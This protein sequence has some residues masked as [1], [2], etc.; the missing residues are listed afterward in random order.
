MARPAAE[1]AAPV[2]PAGPAGPGAAGILRLLAPLPGRLEL[3]TRVAAA[4]AL[5]VLVTSLYGT[6][7]AAIS[8]YLVFFLNRADRTSSVVMSIGALVLISLVI[9]LVLL[10]AMASIDWPLW[11]VMWMTVLSAGLLFLTSASKLRP[12]G[13][14]LAMIVGFGLDQLGLAPVG[15]AATRALLYAWLMVAIPIGANVAINLLMAPSPRRLAGR[16]LAAGLRLAADELRAPASTAPALQAC[17][18]EGLEPVAG[19]LKLARLE[20]SVTP[21]DAAALHQALASTTTILLAAQLAGREP[22]ARLP[23]AIAAALADG[24]EAM[25][26]MLHAGGYPVEIEPP[27][28]PAAVAGLPPLARAVTVELQQAMV[29]FAAP[30][31]MPVP[32]PT[33]AAEGGSK[34]GAGSARKGGFLLPDAFT[35]PAHVRYALKT[36]AAAM[37]CY[38]LYAQLDWPG[39][40]TCF[41]TCY[42]VSLGTTAETVEKLTLRIAGCAVGAVF[43]TAAL[44][45]VT[46]T[47]TSIGG[48]I[49]LVFAGAWLSAW[50]A[51]GSPRIAYAGFQIAFA[52]FL[53]VLQGAAPGFD[54][55]IARDR[56]IG[57]LVGN[58]AVYLVFTR[59]WPVSIAASIDAAL[60]ELWRLWERLLGGAGPEPR[61]AVVAGLLARQGQLGEHIALAR[62]EP[63]GIRP[64]SA[65][66]AERRLALA[67]AE[68]V[69]GPLALLAVR[70]PG[71]AGAVERLRR[72]AGRSRGAPP[73]EAGAT[74][75]AS[76]ARSDDG[77]R[78]SLL[79]LID[80][81]L[82]AVAP[83]PAPDDPRESPIHAPT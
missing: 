7:E 45:F 83:A 24:L 29:G 32:V 82:T 28:A 20:G 48:L 18:R 38:L 79:A 39:I 42:V 37:F 53:C 36:T 13:A 77:L 59:L 43:G 21:A 67:R 80:Q 81:R 73:L 33:T 61:G 9:G 71:D 70:W 76:G 22:A 26:A 55:T 15:E 78:A 66:L 4:A 6:P 44:V 60:D 63:A 54:L 19:W 35:N 50:V 69:A 27:L 74:T 56:V 47:L 23:A 1:P 25:A 30:A 49:A 34:A 2:D 52:F 10:V 68:A 5:T 65:W 58:L 41:I 8:A 64:A 11:R 51:E 57:I 12:V 16:R 31:P 75:M 72:A 3:T 14:I 46:P 62:Y 17:L 40:H